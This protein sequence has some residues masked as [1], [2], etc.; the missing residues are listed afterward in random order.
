MARVVAWHSS[1]RCLGSPF[2]PLAPLRGAEPL[3]PQ[4][5][6]PSG[7][8]AEAGEHRLYR[9]SLSWLAGASQKP[10]F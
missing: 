5:L 7:C 4:P 10:P 9:L 1:A 6:L 2:L 8:L 3:F